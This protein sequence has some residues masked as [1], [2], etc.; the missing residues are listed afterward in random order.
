MINK[1][2]LFRQ[3]HIYLSL[4]FLPCAMVFALTG[5][6]YIFGFNKS[7]GSKEQNYTLETKI[8]QGKEVEALLDFLKENNIK[9]PSNTRPI[10]SKAKGVT[11]GSPHYSINIVEN[12][13]N[14]YKIT[15]KTMGLLGDL[16]ILHENKGNRYFSVLSAGFGITLFLLYISGLVITLF[17]SKKDRRNQILV[18]VAG[19][20]TTLALAYAS[21]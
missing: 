14:L 5:M 6:A 11:I 13:E 7:F 20:L 12:G 8:E 21:L 9:I 15:T 18:L 3:I 1:N 4:F 10:K 17:A 16:M 19:T 2:K